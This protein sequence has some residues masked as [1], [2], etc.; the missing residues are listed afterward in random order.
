MDE[1]RLEELE[2]KLAYQE[3][4]VQSLNL[5]IYEQQKEIDQLK[6]MNGLVMNRLQNLSDRMEDRNDPKDEKPPHY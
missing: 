6:E 2:V 1:Q 5:R 4:L 3:D